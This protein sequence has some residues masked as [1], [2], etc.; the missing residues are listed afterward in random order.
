MVH[1]VRMDEFG[2]LWVPWNSL[3][4]FRH[5]SSAIGINKTIQNIWCRK[6]VFPVLHFSLFNENEWTRHWI[7]EKYFRQSKRN[8]FSCVIKA[9]NQGSS[10]GWVFW[11]KQMNRNYWMLFNMAFSFELLMQI[12]EQTGWNETGRIY[13]YAHWYPW[14]NQDSVLLKVVH[15]KMLFIILNIC[16]IK[17]NPVFQMGKK[18]STGKSG[19]GGRFSSKDLFPEKNFHALW[20][21]MKMVSLWL[22]LDWNQKRKRTFRLPFKI[23]AGLSGK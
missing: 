4:R 8:R 18:N 22:Y 20:S 23:F 5:F 14:R 13:P 2:T 12:M 9:A 11:L 16:S 15:R 1:L 6:Q 10:I 3:L 19:C 17:S 21:G 7:E